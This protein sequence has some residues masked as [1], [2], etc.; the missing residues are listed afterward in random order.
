MWIQFYVFLR[1]NK[2][3]FGHNAHIS[4][5][6]LAILKER[7]ELVFFVNKYKPLKKCKIQNSRKIEKKKK[8]SRLHR[9]FEKVKSGQFSDLN[10]L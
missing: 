10:I 5:W 4:W 6:F 2:C 7:K 3:S 8:K 9:D 1:Q